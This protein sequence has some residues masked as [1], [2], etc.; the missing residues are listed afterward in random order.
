MII[1][2]IIFFKYYMEKYTNSKLNSGNTE[3]KFACSEKRKYAK[4][5]VLHK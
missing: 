1:L 2:I 3:Y 4:Q 5:I